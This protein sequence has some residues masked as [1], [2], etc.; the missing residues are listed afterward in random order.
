LKTYL[1]SDSSNDEAIA[2]TDL[3]LSTLMI[4]ITLTLVMLV[5]ANLKRDPDMLNHLDELNKVRVEDARLTQQLHEVQ[6]EISQ[7]ENQVRKMIHQGQ[8]VSSTLVEQLPEEAIERVA[9]ELLQSQLNE[10]MEDSDENSL[11]SDQLEAIKD[12]LSSQLSRLVGEMDQ[13]NRY[14]NNGDQMTTMILKFKESMGS[15]EVIFGTAGSHGF[16]VDEFS[17]VLE[18]IQRGDGIRWIGPP[19]TG[20]PSDRSLRAVFSHRAL[21]HYS[22]AY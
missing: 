11:A 10:K 6:I 19:I 1:Q 2:L 22:L 5:A 4:F 15:L 21:R 18:A 12:D 3:S 9:Y 20:R 8:S 17:Q 7:L 13:H 16:D 14:R